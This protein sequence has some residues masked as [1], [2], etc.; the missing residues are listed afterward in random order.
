[1][2]DGQPLGIEVEDIYLLTDL[3]CRGKV[4]RFKA[5]NIGGMTVE[6]YIAL[7]CMARTHKVRSQIPSREITRLDLR[8]ILATI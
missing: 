7:Y 3:S 1:M 4:V 8:I 2:L 5:H 6:E